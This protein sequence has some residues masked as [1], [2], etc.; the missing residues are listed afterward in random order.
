[1]QPNSNT[2]FSPAHLTAEQIQRIK[3]LESE[4]RN[5]ANENIVLIAY[6]SE[7]KG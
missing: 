7:N 2:D 4:L 5:Q 1:M 6:E 3:N